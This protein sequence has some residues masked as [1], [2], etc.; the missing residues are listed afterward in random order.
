MNYIKRAR[1]E[2]KFP[3]FDLILDVLLMLEVIDDA[4][5]VFR[6]NHLPWYLPRSDSSSHRTKMSTKLRDSDN[7]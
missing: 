2:V 1:V 6:L 7:K 5:R 3:Y 4:L